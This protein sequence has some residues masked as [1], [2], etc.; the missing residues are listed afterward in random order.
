MFCG[1]VHR[2]ITCPKMSTNCFEDIVAFWRNSFKQFDFEGFMILMGGDLI[3]I[4]YN[5]ENFKE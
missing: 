2:A 1:H 4:G 3:D 5:L